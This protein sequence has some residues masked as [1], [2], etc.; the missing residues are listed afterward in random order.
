M[1][2]CS[3]FVRLP[4]HAEEE[5]FEFHGKFKIIPKFSA[6]FRVDDNFFKSETHEREVHTYMVDPGIELGYDTERSR[7]IL[8][9]T[10]RA[11]FYDYRDGPAP[12]S[13]E[14]D[15]RDD[16]IGHDLTFKA[17]TTP[18]DRLTL[19]VRDDYHKTVDSA[20]ADRFSNS[21]E[22]ENITVNTFRPEIIYRFGPKFSTK[23]AYQNK[24]TRYERES[25]DD[26]TEHRGIFDVIYH[27]TRRLSADLQYQHWK[28]DYDGKTVDYD[29]DEISLDV[30]KQFKYLSILGGAGYHHRTFDGGEPGDQD[31]FS[32]RAG[33]RAQNPPA[34]N[35]NPRSAVSFTVERNFNT[36]A[37]TGNNYYEATQF[38]LIA[39]HIFMEKILTTAA[40]RYRILNYETWDDGLNTETG[41]RE[42]DVY[43]IS[44]GA[45]Y[46]FT[47]WL[48]FLAKIGYEERDSNLSGYGYENKYFEAKVTGFFDLGS[49]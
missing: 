4:G 36:I 5:D 43:D 12:G 45:G 33:L 29:S 6:G 47:D 30:T 21:R 7:V 15:D 38:D 22:R 20:Q 39:Q 23:A 32:F 48:T 14:T 11:R 31:T 9:Y 1:L 19:G 27:F 26:S 18:F 42:D 25:V 46:F 13:R 37:G 35:P 16:Y 10:L 2:G 8:D 34:P 17:S 28:M 49:K 40:S 24:I 3:L 44:L 41:T